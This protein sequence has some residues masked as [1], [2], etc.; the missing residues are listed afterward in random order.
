M[1]NRNSGRWGIDPKRFID[2]TGQRF[3]RWTILHRAENN[4]WNQI[5]WMC[6]CDCGWKG[7]V[8]AKTLRSGESRS[9]GCLASEKTSRRM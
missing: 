9:C 1:G 5:T 7:R 8:S 2:L 6:L 3:T 4:S